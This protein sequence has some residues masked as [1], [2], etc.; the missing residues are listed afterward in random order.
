MKKIVTGVII[1]IILVGVITGIVLLKKPYTSLSTNT[2]G[3]GT[4]TSQQ[5]L[6]LAKEQEAKQQE[7][8]NLGTKPGVVATSTDGKVMTY[9]HFNYKF[10]FN[11]PIGWFIE[12]NPLYTGAVTL[13]NTNPKNVQGEGVGPANMTEVYITIIPANQ[14]NEQNNPQIKTDTVTINNVAYNHQ[15]WTGNYGKKISS[16]STALPINPDFS[17]SITFYNDNVE[18]HIALNNIIHSIKWLP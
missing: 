5:L 10:S 9:T 3:V 2:N 16:Y 7:F 18:N 13:Y 15:E 14:N 6:S 17:L 11:Y 1:L 8:I 4:S 12:N